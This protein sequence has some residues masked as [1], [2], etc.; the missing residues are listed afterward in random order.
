MLDCCCTKWLTWGLLVIMVLVFLFKRIIR[1]VSIP[2][3]QMP[4]TENEQHFLDPKTNQKIK[5]P[6]ILNSAS[7]YLSV[8]VPSYN[9]EAR[10]PTMLDEALE[11]LE[12]RNRA[13]SS[14]TYEIIV[15]D[16]GSKDSTSKVALEYSK[17]YSSETVR[18]LTQD[19]NRGK[20]GA[21]RMGVMKCRGKLILF[22][23][24]DGASKFSDFERL[25]KIVKTN[26]SSLEN[27][28]IVACGSRRHLEKDSIAKRSLFRTILMHGFHFLVW[29]LCV[30]GVRDTQCGF[31]LLTRPAAIDAFSNL[32][33]LRWAFDVDLLYIAQYLKMPIF[34]VDI[35]WHECEG[36]K[37]TFGS[38][39]QMGLDLLSIRLH[40]LF[41]AWKINPN[42]RL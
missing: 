9:E 40:Y 16:D 20:G 21:V 39:I 35:N 38:Y 41:G 13:D 32:H 15:V 3:A 1:A 34:E 30:K 7:L 22:A 10:L 8:I 4:Q 2:Y 28:K 12:K 42:H 14:F 31:K 19:F 26:S 37:I 18:V 33:V 25:E 36:S 27:D 24:A 5:F 29:F 11:Y 6:S 23:D 17:K